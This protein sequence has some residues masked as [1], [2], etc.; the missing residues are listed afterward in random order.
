M[1]NFFSLS[2]ELRDQVYKNVLFTPFPYPSSPD[3]CRTTHYSIRNPTEG[4]NLGYKCVA[5]A[6]PQ[7]SSS[8]LLINRQIHS[9][10]CEILHGVIRANKLV[11]RLDCIVENIG[12]LYVT[13]TLIPAITPR[14]N[15]LEITLRFFGN[16]ELQ[17]GCA[18]LWRYSLV[19]MLNEFLTKGPWLPFPPKNAKE[20]KINIDT[21]NVDF[22]TVPS[23]PQ[24]IAAS[25]LLVRSNEGGRKPAG[26][27]A[28]LRM[29]ERELSGV[30]DTP[31]SM[32]RDNEILC[33]QVRWIRSLDDGQMRREWDMREIKSKYG[34]V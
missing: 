19:C 25:S 28:G 6:R 10:A 14:V 13:P 21:I 9:E 12:R 27:E 17:R 7:I 16:Y 34:L 23:V 5:Y 33:E 24:W 22:L 1:S 18:A 2:R 26:Q 15:R 20:E 32:I 11:Y 8:S 3:D 4:G 29:V 31:P 30:F